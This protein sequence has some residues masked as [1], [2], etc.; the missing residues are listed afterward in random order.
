MNKY[1][2]TNPNNNIVLDYKSRT[3]GG[4]GDNN[5]RNYKGDLKIPLLDGHTM[6]LTGFN[7]SFSERNSKVFLNGEFNHNFNG[8][9]SSQMYNLYNGKLTQLQKMQIIMPNIETDKFESTYR[10]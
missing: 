10:R 7:S 6:S 2:I 9:H 5:N 4:T 3:T 1:R 8:K